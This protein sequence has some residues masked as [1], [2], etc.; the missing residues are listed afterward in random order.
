MVKHSFTKQERLCS[1][2]AI[3]WFFDGKGRAFTAHPLRIVYKAQTGEDEST[4]HLPQILISVSK[5]KF[6]NAVDRNRTK[7][8]IR[9]AYRLEKA[10]LA[11]FCEENK[12]CELTIAFIFIGNAL[13][14]FEEIRQALRSSLA[15][16]VKSLQ[17]EGSL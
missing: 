1:L 14:S 9:E 6:H 12:R 5:K 7:R 2:S 8:L 15:R 10:A 13:P 16:I 11:A 4:A 17:H 3:E